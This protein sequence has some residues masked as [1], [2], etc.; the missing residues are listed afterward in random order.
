MGRS[1]RDTLARIKSRK[2]C[3]AVECWHLRSVVL[4]DSE[5][6][7]V[8]SHYFHKPAHDLVTHVYLLKLLFSDPLSLQP[9]CR[10]T[11]G[12]TA[13][14]S[15]TDACQHIDGLQVLVYDTMQI[16]ATRLQST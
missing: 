7:A 15:I 5:S 16:A 9:K 4:S 14:A 3:H 8:G 12:T 6:R 13:F 11:Q 2:R 1:C 10:H